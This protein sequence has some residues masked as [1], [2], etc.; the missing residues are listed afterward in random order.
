M[1]VEMNIDYLLEI[2]VLGKNV[3]QIECDARVDGAI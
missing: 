1:T 3:K 2:K